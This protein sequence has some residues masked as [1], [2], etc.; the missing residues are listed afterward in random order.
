[1]LYSLF[2]LTVGI[3]L[4]QEYAI[5]PSVKILGITILNNLRKI[6][7]ENNNKETQDETLY[8]SFLKY[9]GYKTE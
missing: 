4:G 5:L 7:D 9:F 1:M 6:S 2:V 3:Y 8:N